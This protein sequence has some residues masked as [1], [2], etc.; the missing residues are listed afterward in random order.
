VMQQLQDPYQLQYL[1]H[2]WL[3]A[4]I[5]RTGWLQYQ[6]VSTGEKVADWHTKLGP[7]LVC[8]KTHKR[9]SYTHWGRRL[10][11]NMSVRCSAIVEQSF[12]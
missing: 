7:C 1:P 2:H 11:R 8:D 4:S 12:L 9:Q 3:L 5:G 6:D 10:L